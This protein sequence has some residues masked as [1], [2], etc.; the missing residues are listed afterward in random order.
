[1]AGFLVYSWL[2]FIGLLFFWR[3]YRVAISARSDVAYLKWIVLLP[4]LM[5]WPSAVGKDAFMVLAMGIASYGAACLLS[6]RLVPGLIAISAGI[7]GMCEVRPHVALV[8]SS[9]LALAVLFRRQR[10]G[11]LKALVSFAFVIGAGLVVMSAASTFFG[12]QTFSRASIQKQIDDSSHRTSDGGS[13]FSPA[14]VNSPV[15]IPLAAVT[16]LYRPLP[17]EAHSFQVALTGVEGAT[18]ALI[19]IRKLGRIRRAIR[20]SRDHPYF[21]YAIGA[22]LVFIIAFSGFSNFGILA[23]QRA[24]IQPLLLLFIGLPVDV[25]ADLAPDGRAPRARRLTHLGAPS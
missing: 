6:G 13:E 8:V 11:A 1:M 5:Y 16:V 17:F 19:T 18:L 4:T 21:L 14:V 10:G 12:I 2:S 23:R 20:H 25:D 9:G 3:A 24:V 7:A 22:I 15:D